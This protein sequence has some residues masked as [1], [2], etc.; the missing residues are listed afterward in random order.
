M[1]QNIRLARALLIVGFVL[2]GWGVLAGSRS[3]TLFG[4]LVVL[5]GLAFLRPPR[6][7]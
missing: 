6:D 3:L 5:V 1:R 4:L 2:S 7:A